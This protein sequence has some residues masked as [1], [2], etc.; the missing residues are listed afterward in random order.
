MILR[1]ASRTILENLAW[2]P[3]TGII[4]PRQAS[5]ASSTCSATGFWALRSLPNWQGGRMYPSEPK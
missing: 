4:G 2:F 1:E 3:V 5:Q